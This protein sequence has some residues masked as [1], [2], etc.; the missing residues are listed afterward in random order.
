MKIQQLHITEFASFKDRSFDLTGGV[1]VIE[2]RNESGK[3]TL[4]AFIRFMLYGLPE[5]NAVADA[6][7]IRGRAL[8]W[9]GGVAEGSLVIEA[10]DGRFRIERKGTLRTSGTRETY[11]ETVAVFD[12]ATGEKITADP[13][14]GE[15]FLGVNAAVY[16]S[17]TA[18][19]QME[20]RQLNEGDLLASMENLL[21]S[22]DENI[23]AGGGGSQTFTFAVTA[24]TKSGVYPVNLTFAIKRNGGFDLNKSEKETVI[25]GQNWSAFDFDAF[26]ALAGGTIVGAETLYRNTTDCYIFDEDNYKVWEISEGGDGVYHV[27]DKEKYPETNGYGPILVAYITEPCRFIDRSFTTIEE[28]GNS[29][30]VVE[31]IYNYRLFIKGFEAM[32]AEGYYCVTDCL[33]HLDGSLAAC[34]IGCT[35]CSSECT[36]ISEEEMA[37][38]GYASLV[39][40]DG[41]APVTRE[42]VKFLQGFATTQRYFADGEG[43]VESHSKTPIDAYEDSQWLFACGY[44]IN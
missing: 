43:W 2:G 33:C 11:S 35:E 32:A 20:A 4:A 8:S 42:L 27:Y 12:M 24:E 16:D 38:K 1:T 41:V 17:T 7:T 26:N 15:Y 29:A 39:N 30:L 18:I 40:A 21:M 6:A 34:P 25:P 22:A 28:A 9:E 14:P 19:R 36:N 10:R 44:Y 23:S 5:K 37:A 31:G 13:T 3:S